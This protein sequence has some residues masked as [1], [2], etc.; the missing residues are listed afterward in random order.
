MTN[1]ND[2]QIWYEKE[3]KAIENKFTEQLDDCEKELDVEMKTAYDVEIQSRML[4][5]S[6]EERR[7]IG[8][9]IKRYHR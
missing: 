1:L 7:R 9:G 2:K 5:Q 6:R 3:V 8:K 4:Y